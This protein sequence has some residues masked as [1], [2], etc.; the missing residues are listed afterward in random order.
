MLKQAHILVIDDHYEITQLIKLSLERAFHATVHEAQTV[1]Q[2]LIVLKVHKDIQ[3]VVLDINLCLDQPKN[4]HGG[5]VFCCELIREKYPCKAIIAMTGYYNVGSLRQARLAGA[6]DY[7]TK[8]FTIGELGVTL[9]ENLSKVER[10]KEL[11]GE[12][13]FYC[14][15]NGD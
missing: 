7:I 9:L 13:Y 2:A 8:P 6:D 3:I 12:S 10:W 5:G 14:R 15:Q 4:G 11:L 1:D